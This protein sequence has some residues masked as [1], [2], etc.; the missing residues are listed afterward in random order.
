[1][2]FISFKSLS[3]FCLYYS[4]RIARNI[5][6]I[7]IVKSSCESTISV[8]C[9]GGFLSSGLE[10]LTGYWYLLHILKNTLHNI[11]T[12]GIQN[13]GQLPRAFSCLPDCSEQPG[14]QL[15]KTSFGALHES[16]EICGHKLSLGDFPLNMRPRVWSSQLQISSDQHC[17]WNQMGLLVSFINIQWWESIDMLISDMNLSQWPLL[18]NDAACIKMK[19]T[20]KSILIFLNSWQRVHKERW[21]RALAHI[22]IHVHLH[23]V[24][25]SPHSH[26][27]AF[28]IPLRNQ[29]FEFMKFKKLNFF[30]KVKK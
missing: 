3:F 21:G 24:C 12:C 30:F 18:N 13:A 19:V 26:L 16:L 17:I 7:R 10:C 1:M 22:A 27:H 28:K 9:V 5:L 14:S 15:W 25:L 23:N 6:T 4:W 8:K 29:L 11:F 20:V 2:C